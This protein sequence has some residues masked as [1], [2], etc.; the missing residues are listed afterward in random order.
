[1]TKLL[2]PD[3]EKAMSLPLGIASPLWLMFAGAAA[4]G[5]AVFWA[6]AWMKPVNIEALIPLPM[7]ASDTDEPM[8]EAVE[9]AVMAAVEATDAMV[10]VAAD[11]IDTVVEASVE[12]DKLLVE[13]A[14]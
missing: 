6:R 10:E 8:V 11:A 3:A 5:A 1:M 14:E 4:A 9:R 13:T 2:T 12:T 7:A